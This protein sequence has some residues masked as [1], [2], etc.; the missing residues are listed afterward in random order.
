[1]MLV[2]IIRKPRK[3]APRDRAA[4][5]AT[6]LLQTV[7]G[8]FIEHWHDNFAGADLH[9]M[10]ATTLRDEFAELARQVAAERDNPLNEE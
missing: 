9:E 2:P 4:V 3:A 8:Y 6:A 5:V 7:L 10:V 1:M